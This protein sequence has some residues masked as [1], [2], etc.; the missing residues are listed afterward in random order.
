MRAAAKELDFIQAA[1][2]RDEMNA[3]KKRLKEV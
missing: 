3:L 2:H 1:V